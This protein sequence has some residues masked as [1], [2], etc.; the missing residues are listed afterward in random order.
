MTLRNPESDVTDVNSILKKARDLSER[1]QHGFVDYSH[2]FVAILNTDCLASEFCK[3]IDPE[4]WTK[5]LEK[6][7]PTS[8]NN[9]G[10]TTLHFTLLA[11]YVISHCCN[12]LVTIK[13]EQV[14]TS[15]HLLM[16]LLCM[17]TE[18]TAEFSRKGIIFENLAEQYFGKTVE[19]EAPVLRIKRFT[20]YANWE[21]WL[22]PGSRKVK[23]FQLISEYAYFMTLY[24]RYDESILLCKCGLSLFPDDEYLNYAHVLGYVNKRDFKNALPLA[25]DYNKKFPETERFELLLAHICSEAE[26]YEDAE[27]LYASLM[28][29]HPEDAIV[30]N[31]RAFNFYL[32]GRYE[33]AIPLYEKAIQLDPEFAFA[34]DNLGYVLHKCGQTERGLE[35]INKALEMDKGNSFAYKY[36]GVIYLEQGNKEE[37][38]KNFNTALKFHY[39]IKYGNEVNEL[40][41]K[42]QQDY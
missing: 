35:L 38:M 5:W 1:F 31:D 29:N 8:S 42:L 20:P 41:A 14:Y 4:K 30:C 6:Q 32:Q 28:K 12:I 22:M 25:L 24:R 26:R 15:V 10:Q 17:D 9:A 13:G 34:Y 37:A 40:I 33:E 39:T 16:A 3:E 11:D 23:K 36:K 27:I 21:K 19:R 7:F 18:L 2:L